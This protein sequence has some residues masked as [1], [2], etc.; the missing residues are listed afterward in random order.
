MTNGTNA[1]TRLIDLTRNALDSSPRN[2]TAVGNRVFFTAR[3]AKYGRELYRSEGTIPSTIML[4]N[5]QPGSGNA[6]TTGV[7]HAAPLGDSLVFAADNP[8]SES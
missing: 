4:S 8:L 1:G 3:T 5:I 7:L 2:L 6:F